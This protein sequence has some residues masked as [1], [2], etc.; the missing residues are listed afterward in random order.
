MDTETNRVNL[1]ELFVAIQDNNFEVVKEKIKEI[2]NE[3]GNI[4]VLDEGETPLIAAIEYSRGARGQKRGTEIIEELIKAGANVNMPNVEGDSPL[5]KAIH[6][7]NTA[8]AKV[9]L[10]HGANYDE[11]TIHEARRLDA[12]EIDEL[13]TRKAMPAPEMPAEEEEPAGPGAMVAAVGTPP[14]SYNSSSSDDEGGGVAKKHKLRSR[15]KSKTTQKPRKSTQKP[16][17]S[18]QKPR[19]STQKPRKSTQKPRKSTQH[20]KSNKPNHPKRKLKLNLKLKTK[21][22]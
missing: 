19:K 11:P 20:Q 22:R 16:R 8:A 7:N 10:D 3:G 5:L 14:P 15:K 1:I 9:L 13:M 21:R 12:T 18:T 6:K 4:N 17:K 2:K